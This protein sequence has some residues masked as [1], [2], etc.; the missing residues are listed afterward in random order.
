LKQYLLTETTRIKLK[1]P[2]GQLIIGTPKKTMP[3]LQKLIDQK[4]PTKICVVG[5]FLTQKAL[6]YGLNVD[7]WLF[8]GKVMR[9]PVSTNVLPKIN[10]ITI[11]N[12]PG[13]LTAESIKVIKSIT[14]DRPQAIFVKGEEDLLALLVIKY[15]P[16]NT[17]VLHGQPHIGVVA[18]MVTDKMKTEVT[19]LLNQ[20]AI[21]EDSE[22]LK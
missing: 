9:R 21:V 5:D 10:Y 7:L 6:E 14:Y 2:L 17:L 13:T 1:H 15:A 4:K 20:M 3:I 22:S 8:D 19:T 11:H 18:I 12:P 16:L